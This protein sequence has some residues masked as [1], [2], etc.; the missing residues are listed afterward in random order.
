M[1]DSTSS[2]Q[3]TER[4]ALADVSIFPATRAQ[5]VES[6][7]RSYEAWGRGMTLEEYLARDAVMD[8]HE[9]A[10]DGKLVTWVLARRDDPKSLDFFCSIETFKREGFVVDAGAEKGREVACYGLASL[11]TAPRHRKKGYG[12]HLMRMVH[13]VLAPA[14]WL[15]EF[16]REVWGAPPDRAGSGWADA[17][18]VLEGH[19]GDAAFSTLYSDVGP[20][21][22]RACGVVPGAE[23]WVVTEPVSSGWRVDEVGG[24]EEEGWEWL[25]LQGVGECWKADA[26]LMKRE[27]EEMGGGVCAC[28]PDKGVG[29]FQ[30]IRRLGLADKLGIVHWGVRRGDAYASWTVEEQNGAPVLLVTRL[31]AG[32]EDIGKLARV[33]AGHGGRHGIKD[34]EVWG[35]REQFA[36][37]VR[38]WVREDHLS[39]IKSYSGDL[40][41]VFNEK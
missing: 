10:R 24:E 41:W 23:G 18:Q 36:G 34:V 8:G 32:R 37:F 31:R 29:E 12:T 14:E 27:M 22:Y 13:W 30:V 11:F 26:E 28:L 33:V 25:D 35:L 4:V 40:R 16:P 39:S 5:I 21:I 20:E 7:R 9:V 6:R 19:G 38:T 15:P 1:S 17:E 3:E 2:V